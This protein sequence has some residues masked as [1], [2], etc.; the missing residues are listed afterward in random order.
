VSL[1]GDLDAALASI[2]PIPGVAQIHGPGER[3]LLV[4]RPR[5]LRRWSA[6]HLGRGKPPRKGSRP[7]T[8]L[9]EVATAVGYVATTSGFHQ[10]LV[11]ER[12]MARVVP[13][14]ARRDL[15][16]PGFLHLDTAER[17]PRVRVRDSDGGPAGLF[18]PFKDRKAAGRAREELEK[19]FALRPCDY[20]FEPE[21]A[22]AL[23]LGCLYA[24][25]H[26]CSAPCLARIE[27]ES[28]RALSR[29]AASFL[30]RPRQRAEAASE[31]LPPW[32]S[33]IAGSRGIA[34]ERGRSGLE[35]YPV[36][37]WAVLDEQGVKAESLETA[38][39]L[40]RWDAPA[41]PFRDLPWLSAWLH[42]SRRG[43][44]YCVVEDSGVEALAAAI[45]SAPH[46]H[47]E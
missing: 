34:V 35:L 41:E 20:T 44:D 2:P 4:G 5:N 33:A 42:A 32:V 40:V 25:L 47:P 28:Y 43:G 30:A 37:E 14:A 21:P 26:T 17:F 3:S 24:Q 36:R 1:A 15:R 12:L 10:R 39:R 38:V 27:E 45:R 13:L 22:L 29:E 6:S 46:L 9:R 19:R 11:F 31:W 16:P 23:G 18:G 8:D 7:A